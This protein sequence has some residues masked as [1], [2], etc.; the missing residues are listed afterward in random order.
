MQT[1]SYYHPTEI[2]TLFDLMQQYGSSFRLLAGGTDLLVRL[3]SG[4]VKPDAV[5]DIKGIPDLK[6]GIQQTAD[7]IT[8]GGLTL[9]ATLESDPLIKR[10]FP[11]LAEAANNVG[12]VQIRNRATIAGNICNASPAADSAPPLLIYNAKVHCVS[13]NG[14]RILPLREFITGPGRTALSSGELVTE[15]ILPIPSDNQAAAFTRLTRRKGVDLATINLCCQV[16]TSGV[17]RFAL[18]AVGP[19]PFIVE[20]GDGFLSSTKVSAE[21]KRSRIKAIME[22]ATPIT[23]VRASKEYRQAMLTV[24]GQRALTMALER[25]QA[26]Q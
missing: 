15:I 2:S 14:S 18:G 23:D 8:L 5:I 19:V 12:S 11:A 24:L 3:K 17:T 21:D 16:S 1:F 22:Q 6:G 7:F 26:V 13:S 25:F 10:S 20:E 9:M 4:R